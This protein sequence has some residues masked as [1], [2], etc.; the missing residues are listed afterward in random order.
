VNAKIVKVGANVK[1]ADHNFLKTYTLTLLQG[2]DLLE[3]DSATRFLVNEAFVRALGFEN[4]QDALGL[5]VTMWGR[6]ANISGIVKDF[7]TNS[8][9]QRLRPTIMFCG[10]GS[11][12]QGGVRISTQDLSATLGKVKDAWESVYPK[13]VFESQFLDETIASFYDGERKNAYLIGIFAGVA[14]FIGCIGLFGLVSFMARAKTKEVGIRKTLGASVT[15]VIALFSKEF[16]V[17][18][19]IS[20]VISAPLA[21]YFME[22]WLE[23]FQ[24]RIHPG[25][26]TFLIGVGVT[27]MVVLGTVGIKS[28]NA[29]IANPVDSLRDE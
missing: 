1:I 20:F 14:I 15:Q 18:V 7:N 6:K 10:T 28:Y 16:V 22:G 23:N 13:Y 3:A 2:E 19:V 24:Y 11:Y 27:I 12:F 25:I 8:L 17:L 26:S 21:Y 4:P 29:A 9:H 5:Y